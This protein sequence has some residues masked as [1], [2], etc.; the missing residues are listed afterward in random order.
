MAKHPEIYE[1][2]EKFKSQLDSQKNTVLYCTPQVADWFVNT[3]YESKLRYGQAV[4]VTRWNDEVSLVPVRWSLDENT[5]QWGWVEVEVPF[6]L[7]Y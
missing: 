2:F 5:R 4:K 3:E 7:N 6:K 1:D